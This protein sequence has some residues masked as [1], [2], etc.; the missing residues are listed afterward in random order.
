MNR[1]ADGIVAAIGV[2]AGALAAATIVKATQSQDRQRRPGIADT[3]GTARL[4]VAPAL[5]ATRMGKKVDAHIHAARAFNRSSA[6]LAWSALAD[7]AIEHYRGSF[8]NRAMFAPLI[9]GTLSLA[10]GIHGG[11]DDMGSRHPLRNAIYLAAAGVGVAG[12][13][14]HLYNVTKRPGRFSWHNLFYGAP[15]GAPAALLLSGALGAVGE[16]LRDEP[17]HDPRLFGM[18]AGK[19]LAWVA[20]AG[21]IGTVGEVALLHFR[22]AFHN[23]V[24]YA[25]VTIPPIAAALLARAALAPPRAN[26]WT[27]FWLR[28]TAALGAIGV[29]FHIR[30]VA[31]NQGGWR[32]WSQNVLNGPPLPAPPGFTALATAGLAALR[33]RETER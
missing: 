17:A 11:A 21:M 2:A 7:S 30:G 16:R 18:P 1:T 10:A 28:V 19:A 24:M 23:R 29:G 3:L 26:R 5:Q 22:G 13:G 12:T 8:E 33:L 9:V 32:N 14:F 4:V 25:P 27:R 15:L 20:A 31:R 6:L